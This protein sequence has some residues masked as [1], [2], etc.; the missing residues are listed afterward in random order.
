MRTFDEIWA[1]AAERKGG[2]AAV[3]ALMPELRTADE[4][5][6]LS[7]DRVLATMARVVFNSGFNWKVIDKKWPGFEEAFEGFVPVR[8]KFMSDDDQDSLLKDTRIVR[9][10]AKI[11]S[12]RDNAILVCD[13]EDEYGSAAGAI[14][15]WPVTD[16]AGLLEMLKKRGSRLG[17]HTGQYFLRFLGKDGYVM[18]KDVVAALVRE[19]VVEK[20]PTSKAAWKAVQDAFNTWAAQSGRPVAHIS[21]TLALSVGV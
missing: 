3:E 2:D 10:G 9:H 1:I 5:R 20:E 13:L 6:A 19:G 12:V 18:S 16:Q 15:D 7:D 11:L 21:R 8:W 4:I 17:G 14:A